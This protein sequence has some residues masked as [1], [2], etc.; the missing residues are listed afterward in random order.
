MSTLTALA[1]GLV[2]VLAG[3]SL[4]A[5]GAQLVAREQAQTAAD[6]GALAGAARAVEG[7]DAACARARQLVAA[8]DGTVLRCE[9]D[10]LDLT[11]E[12]QVV[13]GA[14]GAAATAV[15][16]PVRITEDTDP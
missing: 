2:F 7:A 13:T 5:T 12:A 14:G 6:L 1:L 3:T 4:A 10:G 9:L 15:A 11:V 16:G 8:N